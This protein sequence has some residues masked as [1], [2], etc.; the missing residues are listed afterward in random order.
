LALLRRYGSA[1]GV[2]DGGCGSA[3]LGGAMTDEEVGELWQ[4]V[5]Q[6]GEN[7]RYI[8]AYGTAALIRKLVEERADKMAEV[9]YNS[10]NGWQ[11]IKDALADF[12]I[13]ASTWPKEGT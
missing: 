12:G 2:L 10:G 4:L 13:D 3:G 6:D 1:G 5:L 7:D 9:S 8:M 11:Y